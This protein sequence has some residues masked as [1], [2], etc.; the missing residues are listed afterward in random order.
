MANMTPPSNNYSQ[1]RGQSLV[2]YA[3][4]IVLVIFAF[5][6]ALA[7]TGPAIGNV[8]SNTVVNLVGAD[9]R[10]I[11]QLP[12]AEQ[13]WLTVTWV[14]TQT[15]QETPLATRTQS[16]P[17]LPP[18]A[19]PSP[20]HTPITPSPTS[21]HT[22]EPSATPTPEDII[23]PAP[24]VDT[25]N[26][27][28]VSHWRVGN[29]LFLGAADWYGLYYPN[30]QLTGAA[31]H[32]LYN[33]Q[34]DKAFTG[35]MNFSWGNN[36]PI[37]GWQTDNF[38]V[39]WRRTITITPDMG[40][41]TLRF[42]L[43]NVDDSTRLWILGGIYGGNPSVTN[44]GP[45]N[46]SN[47]NNRNNLAVKVTSGGPFYSDLDKDGAG[48]NAYT[49]VNRTTHR[50]Y[51]Q[52]YDDG[53]LGFNP[54]SP[55]GGTNQIPTECLLAENWTSQGAAGSA[56]FTRTV[57]PG[58]YTLQLDYADRTGGAGIR[59][60]IFDA[61][62]G[63]V[64][65][66]DDVRVDSGGLPTTGSVD[67]RWG[68]FTS[69]R[70]DSLQY[71]WNE[72]IAANFW[73]SIPAGQRCHLE[74]RGAVEIPAGMTNPTLTFWDVWN[75][76]SS[77]GARAYLQ[78]AN[79]DPANTG[80]LI[81]SP[82]DRSRLSWQ[83]IPLRT[84]NTWNFNWTY[85]TIDLSPYLLPGQSR[86]LTFRFVIERNASTNGSYHWYVD[87][88]RID[89]MQR[90]TFYTAQTWN[91]DDPSQLGDFVTSGQ[92]ELTSERTL[93]NGTSFH[94]SPNRGTHSFYE[95][96][97][98]NNTMSKPGQ[99]D[100]A[101]LRAHTIEWNGFIDVADPRGATDQDGDQGD[102]IL[103]F[104]HSYDVS[105]YVGLEVQYTTDPFSNRN[106][107]WTTFADGVLVNRN[108]TSNS[109]LAV[110]ERVTIRL[111]NANDTPFTQPVRVRLAMF[112]HRNYQTTLGWW[113][114]EIRLERA[115]RL[116]YTDLP[117]TDD[118]ENEN[119]L[120]GNWVP[121]G[122]WGRVEG[123]YRPIAGTTGHAYTDSP[124]TQYLTPSTSVL[125]LKDAIDLFVDTPQN[126][127]ASNCNL[128]PSSLCLSPL[129]AL[130]DPVLTFQHQRWFSNGVTLAVEWKLKSETSS[131]WRGLWAYADGMRVAQ[132]NPITNS[133][134]PVR[135]DIP[136]N[137][138]RARYNLAWEE[139]MVDLQ[140]IYAALPVDA[141]TNSNRND[142][143]ILIRFRMTVNS[144][145]TRNEG[146]FLDDIRIAERNEMSYALWTK[147]ATRNSIAGTPYRNRYN[148]A[149][150][151]GSG[152]NY[153]DGLDNTAWFNTWSV[154]GNWEAV[155]WEQQEGLLSFHTASTVPS[156]LNNR[157]PSINASIPS[158]MLGNNG[159]LRND[160]LNVLEMRTIIDL[161]G[162]LN[163]ER[164]ILYFWSRHY[165]SDKEYFQVQISVEDSTPI[166][167]TI[168]SVVDPNMKQCYERQLGWG[169]WTT[170]WQARDSRNYAWTRQQI[171]LG[172]YARTTTTD[173]K[174]IRVRFI[175]DALDSGTRRDG[176]YIDGVQVTLYNPNIISIGKVAGTTTFFDSARNTINWLREG[177][178]GL[179]PAVFRG[180]GGGPSSL[181]G[182]WAYDIW[183]WGSSGSNRV[184]LNCSGL[185]TNTCL[186]RALDGTLSGNN[187]TSG[188]R[189][190]SGV[191]TEIRENWGSS[192]PR[193][194]DGN[195]ITDRYAYRW[196]L[197]TPASGINPGR[198]S[199]ITSADDGV[200]LRYFKTNG[201]A[202]PPALPDDPP[203]Y[204]SPPWNIVNNWQNQGRTT[205]VSSARIE[206]FTQYTF[207]MEYYEDSGDASV[208]LSLGSFS[209]SFTAAEPVGS[210]RLASEQ[211]P[212]EARASYSMMLNSAL[213]LSKAVAPIISYYTYYELGGSG[214]TEVSVDGGFTW[215]RDFLEGRPISTTGLRPASIYTSPWHGYYWNNKSLDFSVTGGYKAYTPNPID[216]NSAPTVAAGWRPT[217]TPNVAVNATSTSVTT[218]NGVT[219]YRNDGLQS[220]LNF[221]WAS[222]RPFTGINTSN[223]SVRWLKSIYVDPS[224]VNTTYKFTVAGDDGFRLWLN[225][226]P[227]CAWRDNNNP[228]GTYIFSGGPN[229]GQ[230]DH[231]RGDTSAA[232]QRTSCL[233]IDDWE[234]QGTDTESVT[235]TLPPGHH[236]IQL[237]YYGGGQPNNI[238]FSMSQG[239]FSSTRVTGIY[240]PDDGD[241]QLRTHDLSAYAGAGS[242][243][244]LLRF[245]LDRLSEESSSVDP[246]N[247]SGA[248]FDYRVSWWLTDI[249]IVDP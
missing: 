132:G 155:A 172:I 201:T 80:T 18:T 182:T 223:Y 60:E 214:Y 12:D 86:R 61:T 95:D 57:P 43:S 198:Y 129:T 104:Y 181:N 187:F 115:D 55:I 70:T 93:G 165:A 7:A 138:D 218:Y 228:V 240:T 233:L 45:G 224:Q 141:R 46:C 56:N 6:L 84:G 105:R 3:L 156:D 40:N 145:V 146:L 21:T 176:W 241:W 74:L 77:T 72:Y 127:R 22:P 135:N 128:V 175:A 190:H 122:T 136:S 206:A 213:D 2:E 230:T 100:T 234:D 247:T 103:T 204:S 33:Q 159:D 166:T 222:A 124:T 116:R 164:P 42:Q 215:T 191:V 94:E 53:G 30:T 91:L 231:T 111:R 44:G 140:P 98:G 106:P 196:T 118:V 227:G 67:C 177:D 237:D 87:S 160:T 126:P 16:P 1:E 212:A 158:P 221:D 19:G 66:P 199:F 5:G 113:I 152:T 117:F 197:T 217:G 50:N 229:N 24:W 149:N 147:D 11:A 200:R 99:L 139:V 85:N 161:R 97:I 225:Y 245:R 134:T 8:F 63:H 243:P 170:V 205:T 92:W 242:V 75:L 123:G 120:L 25:G 183:N 125:E 180:G 144:G 9:P 107:T 167:C 232:W 83:T 26:P 131:Q 179:T 153:F 248:T 150:T 185:A 29:G 216:S 157:A 203:A 143:D 82:A 31:S 10:S 78:I 59:L 154:G 14:A 119:N 210:G 13:F 41:T 109:Q 62:P 208:Q 174:R 58:Q 148:T 32:L 20:T 249:Q 133:S 64:T 188:N 244:L 238:S 171:D 49:T 207:V 35:I 37:A 76:G 162:T 189:W 38:G 102:P 69:G 121:I 39:V 184:S 168:N 236:V 219:A 15:P 178:W 114:D 79:Y 239:S 36:S 108:N 88:M 211:R 96:R 73:D 235:R 110:M 202:L 28:T 226:T 65:N 193:R 52:L 151:L 27:E 47:A 220:G 137:G 142:D 186:G 209:F 54:N 23:H 68:N 192:G 101:N 173:G 34:I 48:S 81:S 51:W 89:N 163:T 130:T 194:S 4:I 246:N 112:V 17:T 169:P 90:Q 195:R 71:G